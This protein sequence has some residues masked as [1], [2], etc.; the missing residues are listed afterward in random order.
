[1]DAPQIPS[2]G[3]D[4][5]LFCPVPTALS[6]LESRARALA[7]TNLP[8]YDTRVIYVAELSK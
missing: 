7:K 2:I 1:M 5:P 6:I 3:E 8:E 4:N